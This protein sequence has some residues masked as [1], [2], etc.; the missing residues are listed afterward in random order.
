MKQFPNQRKNTYTE[1]H[2]PYPYSKD[3]TAIKTAV[4]FDSV[5]KT[6]VGSTCSAE[7]SFIKENSPPDSQ[8]IYDEIVTEAVVGTITI[9]Y[10]RM[11]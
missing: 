2:S 3:G 6:N 5:S 7:S 4:E 1:R 9:I 8:I 10:N 11:S